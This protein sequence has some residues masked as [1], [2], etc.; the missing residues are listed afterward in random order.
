IVVVVLVVIL[1]II[2]VGVSRRHGV[3]Y[4]ASKPPAG[5]D[6]NVLGHVLPPLAPVGCG[7]L[8]TRMLAPLPGA[9][10][11]GGLSAI[12]R[13]LEAPPP[14]EAWRYFP[15]SQFRSLPRVGPANP[16]RA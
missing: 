13:V 6:Q 9:S 15:Q 11:P 1:V 16:W 4:E 12:A 5:Q 7:D 14:G 10:T 8:P 2:A 3:I